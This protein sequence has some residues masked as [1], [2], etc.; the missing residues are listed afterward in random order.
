MSR[1]RLNPEDGSLPLA[2]LA[3]IVV[4]G[5]IGALMVRMIGS[6]EQVRFDRSFAES[7]QVADVGINRGLFALNEGVAIPGPSSPGE[8]V[9]DGTTY[10]WWG[11]QQGARQWDVTSV[12]TA[13][14]GVSRR[15]SARVEERSLFF[16]GAFGDRLVALQG[17]STQVDSYNSATPCAGGVKTD[18][19]GW[20]TSAD[21]GT[22]NGSLGT[23]ERLTFTGNVKVRPGGAFL[24]DYLDNPHTPGSEST[25]DPFGDRCNVSGGASGSLCTETYVRAIDE[26][27]QL[28]SDANTAFIRD[29]FLAPDGACADETSSRYTLQVVDG[30]LKPYEGSSTTSDAMDPTSETFDDFYCLTH[31][32]LTQDLRLHTDAKPEKPVVVFVRDYFKITNPNVNIACFDAAGN[33][34]D[35]KTVK[36]ASNRTVRP[37]AARLQIYVLGQDAN[38]TLKSNTMFAGVI[39][40]PMST[41][42]G[43]NNAPAGANTDIY[44]SIMC[45]EMQNIGNW[46][47]HYDDALGVYGSGA[48]NVSLWHEEPPAG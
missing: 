22:R 48:F 29:K 36:N 5:L 40:A 17:T 6:E 32:D 47:F 20:G 41:C 43:D 18:E 16:P 8:A 19:C 11:E 38:V 27:L 3:A 34:C 42:G 30:R 4:A 1:S 13:A 10:R 35:A 39:Y 21:F 33:V 2:L 25:L 7:L 31:W 46:R 37:Q 14:D 15:L 24:Y 44:G 26:R 45:A 23:N 28:A 12:A 9:V